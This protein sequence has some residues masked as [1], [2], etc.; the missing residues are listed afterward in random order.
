MSPITKQRAFRGYLLGVMLGGCLCGTLLADSEFLWFD[1][2]LTIPLAFLIT[3]PFFA[4]VALL[5][6]TAI[7][8]LS[9]RT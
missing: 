6:S 3:G 2:L 9:A 5:L 7:E 8:K 1:V 4:G